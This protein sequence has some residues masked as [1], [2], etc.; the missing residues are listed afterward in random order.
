MDTQKKDI[1]KAN[2]PIDWF[3][4]GFK[5]PNN[6]EVKTVEKIEGTKDKKSLRWFEIIIKR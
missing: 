3:K 4:Y 1:V 6:P 5:N 2:T